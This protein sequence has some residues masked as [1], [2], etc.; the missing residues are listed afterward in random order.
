MLDWLSLFYFVRNPGSFCRLS[1][2]AIILA[3]AMILLKERHGYQS[4]R[5]SF[6]ELRLASDLA[7]KKIHTLSGKMA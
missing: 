6:S 7:S 3:S 2:K 5:G 4:L 1:L